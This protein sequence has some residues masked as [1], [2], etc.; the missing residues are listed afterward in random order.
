MNRLDICRKEEQ[1]SY[2]IGRKE[3]Q[4]GYLWEGRKNR[5]VTCGDAEQISYLSE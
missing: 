4:I 1:I 5:S 2:P 3:E